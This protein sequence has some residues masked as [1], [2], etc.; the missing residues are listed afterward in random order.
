M[1]GYRDCPNFLDAP[2]K[3]LDAPQLS[4]ERVKL[5]TSNLAY[6]FVD[7]VELKPVKNFGKTEHERIQG[8][9]SFWRVQP[10]ISR[11]GKATNFKFCTYIYTINRTKPLENFGKS[12]LGPS[13]GLPK[14]FRAFTYRAHRVVIFAIARLSCFLNCIV[15]SLHRCRC[16]TCFGSGRRSRSGRRTCERRKFTAQRE[17]SRRT[18]SSLVRSVNN[19]YFLSRRISPLQSKEINK[20][21][22]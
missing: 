12:N 19:N 21:H 4:Q 8:L 16:S 14:I 18:S 5:R 3:K 7:P 15:C 10:I 2:Q 1:D 6:T 17:L 20:I 22:R 13:E 11:M 9:P